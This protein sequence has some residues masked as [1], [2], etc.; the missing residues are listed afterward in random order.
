MT[1]PSLRTG[2]KKDVLEFLIAEAQNHNSI[3]NKKSK[4][5]KDIN[6]K[7]NSW[8][9]ILENLRSAFGEEVCERFNAQRFNR[10]QGDH[11]G[12]PRFDKP[13]EIFDGLAT[14]AITFFFDLDKLAG[15]VRR[16]AIQ[17]GS[18]AIADLTRVLQH[19]NVGV[20]VGSAFWRVI[21]GVASDKTTAQVLDRHVLYA[22]S[23]VIAF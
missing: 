14:T 18:V 3:W 20:K 22:E 5:Y 23:D 16:V 13:G 7:S 15:N 4:D 9:E 17:H 8:L 12:I 11:S 2:P 21:L 1:P 19:D 10:H 6:V